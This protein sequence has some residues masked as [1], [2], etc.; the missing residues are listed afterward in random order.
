MEIVKWT[1]YILEGDSLLDVIEGDTLPHLYKN[2]RE[3]HPEHTIIKSRI[4]K[5]NIY[6]TANGEQ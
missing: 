6:K 2:I 3:Y 5:P 4:I 1:Y